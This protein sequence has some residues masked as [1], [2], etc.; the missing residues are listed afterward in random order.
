MTKKAVIGCTLFVLVALATYFIVDSWRTTVHR[1][2]IPGYP[3]KTVDFI[4]TRAMTGERGYIVRTPDGAETKDAFVSN[5]VT[6]AELRQNSHV[7]YVDETL[8]VFGPHG[9]RLEI[10]GYVP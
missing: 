7:E 2:P 5:D 1:I 4:R 3:D 8:I 9:R 6:V 10:L